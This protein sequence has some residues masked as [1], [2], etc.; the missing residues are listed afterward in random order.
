MTKKKTRPRGG[1]TLAKKYEP[2]R[3]DVSGW[4][5][6][7][8][9]AKVTTSGTVLFSVRLPVEELEAMR[10]A[11][12]SYGVTVSDLVRSAVTLAFQAPSRVVLLGDTTAIGS[13]F[14]VS[15]PDDRSETVVM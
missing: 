2:H 8:V 13:P 15:A 3:G 1:A 4:S 11:A 9:P 6:E 5:A 12:V 10:R 14:H 7:A